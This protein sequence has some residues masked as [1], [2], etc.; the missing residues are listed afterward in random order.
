MPEFR[1]FNV[2]LTYD[3]DDH[4]HVDVTPTP[5]IEAPVATSYDV[6]E[7]ENAGLV[8]SVTLQARDEQ[9]AEWLV[10]RLGRKLQRYG[11]FVNGH[12]STLKK[13]LGA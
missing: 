9:H 12:S 7:D 10:R 4:A 2:A 11:F 6:W 13:K 8:L 1:V 3:R 5:E